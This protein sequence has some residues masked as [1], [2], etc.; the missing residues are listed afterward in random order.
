MRRLISA[1]RD[2]L[3]NTEAVARALYWYSRTGRIPHQYWEQLL[4]AH[5]STN[6]RFTEN[7]NMVTRIARPPR[8]PRPASGLLGVFSV[9]EQKEI[10][11]ALARDGFYVFRHRLDA[12]FCDALRDFAES[13]ECD[14]ETSGNA[15]Q[16]RIKYDRELPISRTYRISEQDSVGDPALQRLMADEVF[17]AIAERYLKTHPVVGG[18]DV[19]WSARFGNEPGS[20]AAQLFHFDFDAPPAWLKLFV[21]VTDVGPESG[22][23]VYVRGSHKPGVAAASHLRARGYERI[24]DDDIVAA[25]GADAVTEITGLRGTVFFADTRGFH[26]GKHPTGGDRLLAQLLYCSPFF[27]EHGTPARLPGN[28]DEFLAAAIAKTPRIYDRFR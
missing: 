9:Q 22:P 25:F 27:A 15:G 3:R 4:A 13:A 2:N 10:V 20:D 12:A 1:V 16:K 28:V 8:R 19:W 23:H 7:L 5:C 17:L 21:Y 6:G 11:S 18:V 26:K 14:I 24:P